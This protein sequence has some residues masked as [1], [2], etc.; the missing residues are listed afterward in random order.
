M[1]GRGE[2]GGE[3]EREMHC[4]QGG[5]GERVK[6]FFCNIEKSPSLFAIPWPLLQS[7]G[8]QPPACKLAGT[9]EQTGGCNFS[10]KGKTKN[11]IPAC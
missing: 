9:V 3:R 2:D 7:L 8:L 4:I 1:R 10:M 5:V 6:N 11:K